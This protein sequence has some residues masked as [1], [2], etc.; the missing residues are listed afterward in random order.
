M[1]PRNLVSFAYLKASRT[2]ADEPHGLLSL[3]INKRQVDH[4][5]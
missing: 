2:S 5:S 3:S 4:V 1:S